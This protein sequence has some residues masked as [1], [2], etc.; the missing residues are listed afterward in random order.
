MTSN[1]QA[2]SPGDP[3]AIGP[4][5]IVGRLGAGGMGA[6]FLGSRVGET[7]AEE[8]V[9]V[10]VIRDE[11]GVDPG[12]RARFA[13][14]VAAGR[15]VASFCTAAMLGSGVHEGRP[16]LITEYID[17]PTLLDHVLERGPL[18][19]GT[20]QGLAVG[21]AAAL[22]AIHG[23]GLIHRDLKPSNV[24]LSVSGPRVID[25]GIARAM[26]ATTSM[27]MTGQLIGSPGWIAPE[28]LLRDSATTAVDIYTWG[29]LVAFAARARHPF[30][31]GEPIA[32]ASR[33]LHGEPELDGVP[34]PLL[35]QVRRALDKDPARR[36]SARD[37]LLQ[38]VGGSAGTS[39]ERATAVLERSWSP[40]PPD[41]DPVPEPP[42]GPRTP[43]P[44][45]P[46]PAGFAQPDA[47]AGFGRPGPPGGFAQPDGFGVAEPS[48][49]PAAQGP[50]GPVPLRRRGPDRVI[51]SLVA[52]LA[53]LLLLGGGLYWAL[54]ERGDGGKRG[55]GG[56]TAAPD[57]FAAVKLSDETGVN[58]P[59]A[60]G[61]VQA[62]VGAPRCG[63]KTHQ[64]LT[65]TGTFCLVDLTLD[66]P[67][68]LNAAP[69]IGRPGV[70]LL[71]EDS[72]RAVAKEFPGGL[73]EKAS[74]LEPGGRTAGTLL[75]DVPAGTDLTGVE[76]TAEGYATPVRI[77]L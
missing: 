57:G 41:P 77:A 73:P 30:G 37:L 36:P 56:T 76:L 45:A 40:P 47:P 46:A 71:G 18:S 12:F 1:A 59:V 33:I 13:Q 66:N 69:G 43:P 9:A 22:T 68:L 67:D 32:M 25:F 35:T 58:R 62:T 17:G 2:L 15:R 24:I 6:V 27:T 21:V 72:L 28:Q 19:Y 75:F 5:T 64:N 38:L 51:A 4:F 70:T 54:E 29:C 53:G 44:Y 20:L 8:L 48:T 26:D 10:K 34:E 16:Y 14:E 42:S 23:A 65:A 61:K 52:T 55:D 49:R 74:S 31:T 3:R 39:D 7:G 60:L 50:T 11:L 63:A